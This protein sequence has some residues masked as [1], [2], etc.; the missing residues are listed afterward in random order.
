[1]RIH[2]KQISPLVRLAEI[3]I[4]SIILLLVSP[5]LI[6]KATYLKLS[7]GQAIE[8]IY[9]HGSIG[10]EIAFWQFTTQGLSQFLGL[11]NVI[12]GELGLVG[13]HYQYAV[14]DYQP[15]LVRPGLMSFEIMH[16]RMGITYDEYVIDPK[17]NTSVTHYLL[18]TLR[19][20]LGYG[21]S[22]KAAVSTQE[23]FT[24][25]KV[26]ISNISMNDAVDSLL[27]AGIG[28]QTKHFA[29]V[30]TDCMNI[31]HG[32]PQYRATLN[33][34]EHV[35]ADGSGLRLAC[36]YNNVALKD[37]VNGTDM[38]PRLCKKAAKKG[39]SIYLL[40]GKP[41]IAEQAAANMQ[42]RYPKLI[43]AGCQH[44]YFNQQQTADVIAQINQS[45][46]HILLVAMGAPKQ[47]QWIQ[48]HLAELKVGAAMGVGG[49]FDF[50]ADAV[51]RAPMALRQMGM[52]WTWRLMQEPKRMWRRY[53]IGNPLFVLRLL[54]AKFSSDTQTQ[55]Q[56]GMQNAKSELQQ[57]AIDSKSIVINSHI[58]NNFAHST[59]KQG[60]WFF[61]K[62]KLN[63]VTKRVFDIVVSACLLVLLSPLFLLTAIA[64]RA[65]SKG[66]ILF[67]QT[68]AGQDNQPFTMWKFRSMYIDA[69][70]RLTQLKQQN[71]MQGGVLFKM[72]AD[73]RITLIG[74]L[75]RKASIDEL[76]Q[77]WNVLKGDMSLVGPRPALPS[78]VTQYQLADRR[79]LMVK[80]GI[81]CIW[82]VSGRSNIPFDKQVELD[83]DY[84]YQQSLSK[85]IQLLFKT[86][87]A[88]LFA[89]GAY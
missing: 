2:T 24:L 58:E 50:Y 15:Y 3:L 16:E 20:L 54:L 70:A 49:L 66:A 7:R 13:C 57:N 22:S 65:E 23:S 80:P 18:A 82:Q 14:V 88:V 81:T 33:Q 27:T 38:F 84:I 8:A 68:R 62:I 46:A 85:D 41:G 1:M 56:T 71:E 25:F 31:A 73:P 89:R 52:E 37:N 60:Q 48:Q 28:Q 34:C 87:P 67:T 44:G 61:I 43:I 83:V 12:K 10:N 74:K 63:Q 32:N 40:G 11:W 86:I 59:S 51:S 26:T 9:L 69:E 29:F 30:N 36:K 55:T 4:S 21:L 64:I 39:V 72:K 42:K 47:E 17:L 75:I 45:N 77:L 19:C 6:V 53:I 79:R 76:P 5:A 78:E 35:F